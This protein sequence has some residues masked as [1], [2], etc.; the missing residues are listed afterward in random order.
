MKTKF[1]DRKFKVFDRPCFLINKDKSLHFLTLGIASYINEVSLEMNFSSKFSVP[2]TLIGRFSSLSW[3][4]TF[5]MGYNHRYR[6]VV[7]PYSFFLKNRLNFLY[8]QVEHRKL[9]HAPHPCKNTTRRN[10]HYQIIVG[11]DV[12]IGRGVTVLGGVKIGSGAIIGAN[13]VVAKDVPPYA[14]VGGNPARIIKYRFEEETVKKF[15]AV[16]WWNWDVEKVLENAPLMNDVETFL[17]K[18][19]S[20][21]LEKIPCETLQELESKD[22]STNTTNEEGFTIL[23]DNSFSITGG[24]VIL[25]NTARKVERFIIL[26]LI[27]IRLNFSTAKTANLL[28]KKFLCLC[29]RE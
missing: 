18:H 14:I 5:I 17:N 6:N 7:S 11:N 23:L 4:L 25:N 24:G 27:L 26:L 28:N 20:P 12:W 13:S 9:S 8:S 15:M 3:N 29:G 16:K 22:I 2:H 10:N 21:E 1:T 19:Y